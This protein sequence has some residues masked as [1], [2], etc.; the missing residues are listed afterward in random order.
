MK[1][2]SLFLLV[3]SITFICMGAVTLAFSH[4]IIARVD[5]INIQF[6][7]IV[8]YMVGSIYALFVKKDD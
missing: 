4:G 3:L 1:Q 6:V 2:I 7:F 5:A 8:L